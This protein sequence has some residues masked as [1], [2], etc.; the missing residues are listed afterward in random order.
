MGGLEAFRPSLGRSARG[1]AVR[2]GRRE[3]IRWRTR[4][5][6]SP[7]ANP[8][9]HSG[10]ASGSLVSLRPHQR[11]E[12]RQRRARRLEPDHRNRLEGGTDLR[13]PTER[14][15]PSTT[16][17]VRRPVST[18][19]T[20]TRAKSANSAHPP[21]RARW[22]ARRCRPLPDPGARS[23]VRPRSGPRGARE[24]AAGPARPTRTPSPIPTGPRRLARS[25]SAAERETKGRRPSSS[26]YWERDRG[27]RGS[28][29][30]A[31][32]GAAA[33]NEKAPGSWGA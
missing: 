12:R 17:P 32:R 9:A 1:E 25:T 31:A 20:T 15:A 6:C 21:S 3:R 16:S 33:R 28:P 10:L 8:R 29:T 7:R 14:S 30:R 2:R 5:T 13:R 26:I 27:R 4:Q 23:P 22:H 18:G 24:G 19:V 11:A